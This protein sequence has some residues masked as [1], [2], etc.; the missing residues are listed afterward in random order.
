MMP[1]RILYL[2]LA[3][4]TLALLAGAAHATTHEFYQGKTI[5]IIVGF[6]A[7]GGFDTYSRII[8]RHIGKH[9]PGNPSAIVENMPGAGSLIAANHLYKVAK[10]DGLAIGN[11]IGGLFMQQVLGN[12]AVE[13]DALRFE[14]IGVPAK[15]GRVCAFT[16]ASGITSMENWMASKTA[17][18]L[19]GLAP[20]S[21]TDDVPKILKVTLGLPIHDEVEKIIAGLFKLE[22]ALVAKLREILK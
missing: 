15:E 21:A 2:I 1:R 17:V 4:A 19:G 6:A 16:K 14:Y 7:G 3:F 8:G 5:R 13:F 11:F 10:P 9:L 20:G 18:K 12:P 22:A